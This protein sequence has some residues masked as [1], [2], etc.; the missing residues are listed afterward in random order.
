VWDR[1]NRGPTRLHF[2]K[3]QRL[4][5]SIPIF[6]VVAVAIAFITRGYLRRLVDLGKRISDL[7]RVPIF[8]ILLISMFIDRVPPVFW[9]VQVIRRI[10]QRCERKIRNIGLILFYSRFQ[11]SFLEYLERHEVEGTDDIS[12]PYYARI[13]RFDALFGTFNH[14]IGHREVR[15]DRELRT[16]GD[17]AEQVPEGPLRRVGAVLYH[18]GKVDSFLEAIMRGPSFFGRLVQP[19]ILESPHF[20]R[21]IH[22][23]DEHVHTTGLF[24]AVVFGLGVA[25]VDHGEPIPL[26]LVADRALTAMDHREVGDL[27]AGLRVVIGNVVSLYFAVLPPVQLNGDN[28]IA[29]VGRV[30]AYRFG[31]AGQSPAFPGGRFI[32]L[33]TGRY[34]ALAL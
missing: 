2:D 32:A 24:D 4:L 31:I 20:R 5:K 27:H 19:H 18:L 13:M 10:A 6:A 23:V 22:F 34:E 9:R 15:G 29:V 25:R 21:W 3:L 26:E 30:V 1:S 28:G 12:P 14:V 17:L 16:V 11:S 33:I 7:Y 8:I